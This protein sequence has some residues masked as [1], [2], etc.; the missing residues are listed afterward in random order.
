IEPGI[1]D[2]YPVNSNDVSKDINLLCDDIDITN[3]AS[4][5]DEHQEETSFQVSNLSLTALAIYVK[6]KS[7]EEF[8][9]NSSDDLLETE[10][11]EKAKRISSETEVSITTIPSILLSHI[12]NLEVMINEDVKS[13][14]ETEVSISA[15]L[16]SK[17]PETVNVFD[18]YNENDG[19][20]F[21][22]NDD[23]FSNDNDDKDY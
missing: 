18:K 15:K 21:D 22:D 9:D 11:N 20:F 17:E 16:I 12:Y 14:L 7:L 2:S 4:N 1:S 5:S 19:E 6:P 10:I 13:L 8:T 3:N 23:E